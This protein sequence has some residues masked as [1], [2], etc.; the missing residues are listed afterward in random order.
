MKVN[1]TPSRWFSIALDDEALSLKSNLHLL[2]GENWA[3]SD[4]AMNISVLL[5]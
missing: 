2:M 3:I 4:P 1:S 5:I